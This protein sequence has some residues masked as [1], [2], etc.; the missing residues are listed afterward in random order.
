VF[1][2]LRVFLAD[3]RVIFRRPA[4]N[5]GVLGRTTR[6]RKTTVRVT[7]QV[8]VSIAVIL[9]S[10]IVIHDSSQSDGTKKTF[11]TLFGMVVGYWLR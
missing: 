4:P 7:M 10:I 1:L 11:C 8:V 6:K 5:V 3:L 9:L 2:T